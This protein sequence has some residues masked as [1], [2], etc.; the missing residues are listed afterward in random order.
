MA[1]PEFIKLERRAHVGVL[2]LSNPD[3]LNA[4]SAAMRVGPVRS[5]RRCV[6]GTPT[7]ST[8]RIAAREMSESTVCTT[9]GK[10]SSMPP[11]GMYSTGSGVAALP[12][13]ARARS[14]T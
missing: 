2:T 1:D 3:R 8:G 6:F 11:S 13:V 5:R 7:T 9:C 12:A 4:L 14:G 10:S